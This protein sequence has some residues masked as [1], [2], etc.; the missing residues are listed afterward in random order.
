MTRTS[1]SFFNSILVNLV[2]IKPRPP[3]EN[4]KCFVDLAMQGIAESI[5]DPTT[6]LTPLPFTPPLRRPSQLNFYRPQTKVQKG[7][8]FTPVSHSVHGG[9]LPHCMLGYTPP[10]EADTPLGSR[11][12]PKQTPSLEAETPEDAD[13]PWQAD[14]PPPQAD[15]YCCASYWNAFLYWNTIIIFFFNDPLMPLLEHRQ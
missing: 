6:L 5:T 1:C 15:G 7:Y 4:A 3:P 10:P 13:N 11:H 12:P 14:T 9:G 8:V 2:P